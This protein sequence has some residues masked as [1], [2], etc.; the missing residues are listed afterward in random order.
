M[1]IRGKWENYQNNTDLQRRAIIFLNNKVFTIQPPLNILEYFSYNS[2]NYYQ[3]KL[4]INHKTWKFIAGNFI[5]SESRNLV[6]FRLQKI[7]RK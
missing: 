5:Y 4:K 6:D 1:E 3:Q 2:I 7:K